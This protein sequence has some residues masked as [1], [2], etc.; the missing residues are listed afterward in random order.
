MWFH[1]KK[2]NTQS[3][4]P[5]LPRFSSAPQQSAENG[6]PLPQYVQTF[7]QPKPVQQ[8][9]ASLPRIEMPPQVITPP[10][11]IPQ[12]QPLFVQKKTYPNESQPI[13]SI[14][15]PRRTQGFEEM[16]E[17]G[18][19]TRVAQGLATKEQGFTAFQ[20]QQQPQ[21]LPLVQPRFV[22]QRPVPMEQ[23]R[24]MSVQESQPVGT[25]EKPVFVKLEQ[26]REVIAN[27]DVLK[28]KIKETEY[29]IDRI[30]ELR[31]QEQSELE[32]CQGNLNKLKEKLLAI[33][34]KLFEV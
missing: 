4:I 12:R 30:E 20:P 2:V 14:Q 7:E 13:M 10:P 21:T 23:P 8:V 25:E 1:K 11:E 28:Q 34:K 27:L 15:E 9:I 16:D 6:Q 19:P 3:D 29:F 24:Q 33:D 17:H 5:T 26:Y 31:A 18:L 22:E 32:N